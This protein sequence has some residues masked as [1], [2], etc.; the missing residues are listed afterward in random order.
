MSQLWPKEDLL[1]AG[2]HASMNLSVFRGSVNC[3]CFMSSLGAGSGLLQSSM[4]TASLHS[5][6]HQVALM[7][8]GH[9][10]SCMHDHSILHIHINFILST[11]VVCSQA[12]PTLGFDYEI[13]VL[14]LY[15]VQVVSSLNELHVTVVCLPI[16]SGT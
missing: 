15:C 10:A 1:Y 9:H 6:T 13:Y 7:Q 8:S 16:G 3:V 11:H 2:Q 4:I 14:C 5:S 12:F